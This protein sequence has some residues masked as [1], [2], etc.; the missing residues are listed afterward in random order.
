M[1][2]PGQGNRL[3]CRPTTSSQVANAAIAGEQA[4]TGP[5]RARPVLVPGPLPLGPDREPAP[6]AGVMTGGRSRVSAVSG[7]G[8]VAA[9]AASRRW[10]NS[11]RVSRPWA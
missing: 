8:M 9:N 3:R 7:L 1:A 2:T 4:Q 10:L 11:S 6:R 5:G